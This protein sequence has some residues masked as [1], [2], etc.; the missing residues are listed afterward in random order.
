[1]PGLTKLTGAVLLVILGFSGCAPKPEGDNQEL[2]V[3]IP[4]ILE[5]LDR[6]VKSRSELEIQFAEVSEALAS[7]ARRRE[8]ELEYY[9]Q[10]LQATPP[11][12]REQ[13]SNQMANSPALQISREESTLTRAY[14][15]SETTAASTCAFHPTSAFLE[16]LLNHVPDNSA[17]STAINECISILEI[18]HKDEMSLKDSSKYSQLRSI[19]DLRPQRSESIRLCAEKLRRESEL[20]GIIAPIS[21]QVAAEN[22]QPPD[23]APAPAPQVSEMATTIVSW[24]PAAVGECNETSIEWIG[25]RLDGQPESGSAVEFTNGVYQVSYD[26]VADLDESKV[27]DAA[28]VCLTAIETECPEGDMRGK[29]YSAY[30]LRTEKVWELANSTHSCGGA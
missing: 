10:I 3:A 30:N 2:L 11:E 21:T 17:I 12:M 26:Q 28:L 5:T 4:E 25:S 24:P 15:D 13:L 27:G 23:L 6:C 20:L 9:K 16:N 19:N 7:G 1:M 29:V 8:R 14:T 22:T 18:T